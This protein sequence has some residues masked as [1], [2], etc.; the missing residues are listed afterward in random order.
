MRFSGDTIGPQAVEELV[1]RRL[2]PIGPKGPCVCSSKA[3][4][5]PG[6]RTRVEASKKRPR[7]AS[8][9]GLH[10]ALGAAGAA[11]AR[12]EGAGKSADGQSVACAAQGEAVACARTPRLQR[13]G[14]SGR[15]ADAPLL[16]VAQVAW[17]LHVFAL[18]WFFSRAARYLAAVCE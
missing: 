5:H 17:L 8:L 12:G 2:E 3:S 11:R 4:F 1:L 7:S 14:R 10:E 15:A 9:D 18:L 16:A 6:P 13:S